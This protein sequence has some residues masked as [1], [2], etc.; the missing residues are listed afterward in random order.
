MRVSSQQF[1]KIR[2]QLNPE[3]SNYKDVNFAK[4]LEENDKGFR[5]EVGY[6]ITYIGCRPKYNKEIVFI[7]K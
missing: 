2:E 3:G 5:A 7:R 6:W 4:I 1:E